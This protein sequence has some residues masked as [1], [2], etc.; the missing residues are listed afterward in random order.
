MPKLL[1]VTT[2]PITLRSF[3]LPFAEH[4]HNMEWDVDALARAASQD[5]LV[6]QA[7]DHV[8]DIDWSRNPLKLRNVSQ[9]V[10]TIAQIVEAESYEIVHVHTPVAAFI[11]RFAL[12]NSRRETGT[13]VLYTAHGFH[14][15]R[16][17]NLFKNLVFLF[18][19]KIAGAW[20]DYLVTINEE[21]FKAAQRWKL[22]KNIYLIPGVGVD[23]EMYSPLSISPNETA[24]INKELLLSDE[25][26]LFLMVAEFNSGKRHQDVLQA[27]A[28]LRDPHIHVAFAGTGRLLEK[29][30][31]LASQLGIDR[32]IHFL[33]WRSNIPVLMRASIA[34]I[35]PSEREG[36]SRSV[37]ESLSLEIPVIGSNARGVGDLLTDECGIVFPVGN[38]E[39]LAAAIRWMA[40]NPDKAHSMGAKGRARIKQNYELAT[41]ITAYEQLY[42]EALKEPSRT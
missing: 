10:E 26:H 24:A 35:M 4:I 20:T 9:I 1:L 11:T 41:I 33:G 12:R 6:K 34:T 17:G 2:L 40:D 39:K 38:I 36:L 25:D 23:I 13:A 19:E 42:S 14:F 21:D 22:A 18:L 29:T 32:Q 31:N 30:R 16:G 8:W 7:F 28:I 5:Q 37:M 15:Y 27:V 3:L